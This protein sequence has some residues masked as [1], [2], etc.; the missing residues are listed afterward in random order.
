M[1]RNGEIGL[2][3]AKRTLRRYWWILPLSTLFL[4]GL[5][6]AATYVLP[7]RYTSETMVLVEQPTV[8]PDYVKPVITEDLSQ[9][10]AAMKE[11]ILSVTRLQPIIEK[12]GLYAP[13][14][15]RVHIEDLVE[16][17]R[18]VV[19][20]RPM[21]PTPGTQS[22]QLPGFYVDVTFDN[23]QL[24]Q[25]ICT[26]I[27]SMFLEQNA[28][29]RK[30]QAKETTTFLSKQLE[31]SKKSL[32]DQ[33]AKLAQFKRQYLGSLP[34]EQQSNL[35]ILTGMNAQLEA[36]T[37]ALSRAQQDKVFNESLLGQQEA[38][39]KASETG[40]NPETAEQQLGA[41]QDQLTSLQA[42]YTPEHPD[43]IKLKNQI[44]E[45]KKRK[46]EAPKNIPSAKG[47]PQVAA[48]EPPQIQQLRARLRQDDMNIADLNKR[49]GQIQDGIRQLQSRVQ[50]SPMVEQQLKE[51]TRNYQTAQD[52]Y[53]DL[54]KKWQN[55]GVA[56]DLVSQQESEQFRVYDPPSLPDRPSFPKK[57]Y[58]AG[59][60]L[61]AGLA[62]GIAFL[63][64][65][66]VGDKS[67][68]TERDVELA[69]KLPVLAL[70]PVLEVLTQGNSKALK[71]QPS[72]G[73]IGT[74][75]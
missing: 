11:K 43:V 45:L 33:D 75:S 41:L 3:E 49:Q 42:R 72:L 14:R 59:G 28:T 20:I 39:W 70:V 32:D 15:S 60:G 48:A 56:G 58:F 2:A 9:R 69:L 55:A 34:E 67:M 65:I 46:A 29:E 52:F 30:R 44:A 54:L 35:N 74:R 26:E 50:A 66:I 10:L 68:H 36:N 57:A 38:T 53:N 37:Q 4:G 19:E 12:F 64:L 71:S 73:A 25:Q 8:G 7:K 51:L 1:V 23:P 18:K 27:T 6:L 22:R 62:L 21:E 61:G 13:D 47:P 17:L 16:R 24:A 31:E 63:Y 5:G 40:Q